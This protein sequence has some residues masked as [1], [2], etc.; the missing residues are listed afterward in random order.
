MLVG[1][2]VIIAMAVMLSTIF[3]MGKIRARRYKRKRLS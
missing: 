1:W 2:L 3:L